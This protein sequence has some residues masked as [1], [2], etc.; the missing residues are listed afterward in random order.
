MSEK[1]KNRPNNSNFN[2]Q[3]Y[4]HKLS[5]FVLLGFV[6]KVIN[7]QCKNIDVKFDKIIEKVINL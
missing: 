7:S 4:R 5:N 6:E 3:F 2:F 1:K